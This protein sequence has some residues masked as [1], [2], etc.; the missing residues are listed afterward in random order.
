V[1]LDERPNRLMRWLGRIVGTTVLIWMSKLF[2][3]SQFQLS[4][5]F[6]LMLLFLNLFIPV[7]AVRM[8]ESQIKSKEYS[9]ETL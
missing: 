8:N 5:Y 6:T 3:T 7:P 1:L 4:Q 9:F 2:I